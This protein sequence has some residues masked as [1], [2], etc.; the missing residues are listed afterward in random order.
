MAFLASLKRL[1]S[2]LIVHTSWWSDGPAALPPS[3]PRVRA[4]LA[5][6]TTVTPMLRAVPARMFMAASM[7]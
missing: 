5:Q 2:L 6:S 4:L 7:S 1:E 3:G